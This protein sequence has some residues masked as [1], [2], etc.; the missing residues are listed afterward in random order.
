M[1]DDHIKNSI[2]K[3]TKGNS[4]YE[5]YFIKGFLYCHF[6][7]PEISNKMLPSLNQLR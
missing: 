3:D 7:K 4:L 2:Q 6:K 5:L 1:L